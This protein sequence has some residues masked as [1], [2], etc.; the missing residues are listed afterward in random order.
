MAKIDENKVLPAEILKEEML[1]AA[2]KSRTSDIHIDPTNSFL[3]I[4][5][6]IDGVLVVWAKRHLLEHETMI[7]HLKILSDLDITKHT[8]P[9][10]GHFVWAS[11]NVENP[12]EK[13]ALD[14]R[15]S[16][17][18]TVYGEAVVMRLFNRRELLVDLKDIGLS[19]DNLKIVKGLINQP[20]GMVLVT[21]PAGAGKSTT[22]YSILNE[23]AGDNRNIVTLED[24]VEYYLDLVRQSQINPDREYNFALG[25]RSVLRQDPDVMMVGEIRDFETTENAIRASLTGRLLLSTLHTNSSVGTIARLLD[26]KVEKDLLAYSLSGIISQRLIRKIC[27]HCR[28][29]DAPAKEILDALGLESTINFM[30]GKGCSNCLNT[31]F[32]GRIGLFEVLKIDEDI[33]HLIIN[34]APM[35]EIQTIAK[36][37]GLKTIREDGIQKILTGATTPEEVLKITL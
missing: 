30:R 19:E 34:G 32:Q 3:L 24:P 8:V 18:P 2:E 29:K 5:F 6:R 21:G 16:F 36:Q 28:V 37:K 33:K 4:R 9:Q 17:F 26:M 11:H 14:V 20:S 1:L 23:L 7:S 12:E 10:E 25:I 15:V 13:R 22:L 35:A 31:G 27:N